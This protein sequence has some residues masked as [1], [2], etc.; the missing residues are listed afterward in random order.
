M[1]YGL[2]AEQMTQMIFDVVNVYANALELIFLKL[3][4]AVKKPINTD[5]RIINGTEKDNISKDFI[6]LFINLLLIL[7]KETISVDKK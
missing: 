7:N 1:Q 3:L 6:E 5:D 2:K 4:K